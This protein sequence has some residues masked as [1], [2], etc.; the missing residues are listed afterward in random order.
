[1]NINRDIH[2]LTDFKRQTSKFIKQ[3]KETHQPVVLTV[4]GK[5]EIVVLDAD[6]Y[7]ELVDQKEHLETIAS[8]SRGLQDARDGKL[9]PAREFFAEFMKANNIEADL[10]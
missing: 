3:L 7:Q 4:N 2:P 10:E 9:T 8:I 1:M 6:S 5:P